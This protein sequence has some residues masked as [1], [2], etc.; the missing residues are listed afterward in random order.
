MS[1]ELLALISLRAIRCPACDAAIAETRDYEA[2]WLDIPQVG[3]RPLKVF[4]SEEVTLLCR[5]CGWNARTKDWRQFLKA[6]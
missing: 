3:G 5:G 4:A 6:P 1:L 2:R